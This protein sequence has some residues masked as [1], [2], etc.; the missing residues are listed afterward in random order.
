MTV[1]M[2]ILLSLSPRG[3]LLYVLAGFI[4]DTLVSL[5]CMK[6]LAWLLGDHHLRDAPDVR[7][8][9]RDVRPSAVV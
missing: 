9:P 5:T 6:R 4:F 8:D 7:P 2:K 3:G 1:Q